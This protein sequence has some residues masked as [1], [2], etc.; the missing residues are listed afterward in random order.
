MCGAVRGRALRARAARA[1]GVSQDWLCGGLRGLEAVTGGAGVS[2][3]VSVH[4]AC[5]GWTMIP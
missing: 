5:P 1:G 4:G 2:S 3:E